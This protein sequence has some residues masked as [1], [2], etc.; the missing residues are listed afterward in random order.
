MIRGAMNAAFEPALSLVLLDPADSPL[1]IDAAIDTGF[2]GFLALPPALVVQLA[3]PQSQFGR[4]VMADG[5]SVRCVYYEA[6]V[7]WDGAIRTVQAAELP[8]TPL[9]GMQFL[10]NH[11]V[12]FDAVRG[13][14]VTVE[15]IP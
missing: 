3:L 13:G 10:R 9:V 6:R 1:L 11:R 8:G 2:S 15:P 14:D 5:S 4:L 7:E 12:T